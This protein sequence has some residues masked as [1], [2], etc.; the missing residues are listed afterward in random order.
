MPTI[1]TERLILRDFVSSDWNAL[2]AFLSDPAV[3]RYMHFFSWDEVRRRQWLASLVQRASDPHRDAYDWAITLRSDGLLI[4]W[5]IIGRSRH[6]TGEG[7]RECGCG[8][9]LNRHYWGQGYMPEALQAAF[10]YAFTVLGTERIHAECEIENTAS[11]RVMQKCG[12]QYE[13]TI[14][15]D[16]GL[17]NWEHR[18]RYVITA[19]TGKTLR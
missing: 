7:M 13:A 8:Y 10:T 4:G 11:A 3:T 16:D 9:A 1:E 14:Y 12:M 17:G 15:D 5:L 18:Y 19:P 6:A 2:N